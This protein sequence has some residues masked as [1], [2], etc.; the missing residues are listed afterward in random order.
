[1]QNE[2]ATEFFIGSN[3]G[4]GFYSY[5]DSFYDLSLIHSLLEQ[6][7]IYYRLVMAQKQTNKLKA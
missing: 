4:R 2:K 7:G 6:K 5:F 3:S 1:M